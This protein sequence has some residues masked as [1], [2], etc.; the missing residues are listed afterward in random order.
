M[1]FNSKLEHL[2]GN[3][4]KITARIVWGVAPA[5]IAGIAVYEFLEDTLEDIKDNGQVIKEVPAIIRDF[6]ANYPERVYKMAAE[7]KERQEN[8]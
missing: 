6:Y 2:V 1:S 5:V 4:P 8:A 3:H 7:I